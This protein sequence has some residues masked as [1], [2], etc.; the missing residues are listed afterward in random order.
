MASSAP[1]TNRRS[2]D[3]VSLRDLLLLIYRRRLLL[4][5]C[6]LLGGFAGVAVLAAVE[7]VYMARA[8]L[9]IEPDRRDHSGSTVASASDTLDSASVDSQVQILASR[10]LAREV[11]EALRLEGDP[12]LAPRPTRFD[13]VA[14]LLPASAAASHEAVPEPPG[15]PVDRFLSQLVVKRE[16]KSHVIAIAYRS[17]DP[18]RAAEI[19]NA[20]AERYMV[21]QRARKQAAAKRQSGWLDERL[22]ALK[23]Q[24]LAA[25]QGLVAFRRESDASRG[26]TFD[27]GADQLAGINVQLVT[28]AV[29]RSAKEAM[30]VRLKRLVASGETSDAVAQL[31]TSPL[32]ANLSALKAEALRREAELTAQYGARHPKIVDIKAEKAKLDARLQEERRAVVRQFESEVEQARAREDT[33]T[34]K[35]EELKGKALRREAAGERL[36]DL[37]REVELSRRLYETHLARVSEEERPQ[38][39]AEPDARVI[40]EAVPP[41]SPSFPDPRLILS[42]SLSSGFLLGLAAL[43][44][45]E[46]GSPGLCS[47]RE[48]ES[49]LG[50]PTL[51][52]TPRLDPRRSGGIAPHD[53]VVERPRSRSA[54]ALRALLAGLLR[55]RGEAGEATDRP[56]V[57]LVTSSLPREGKSTL[58][59]SLARIAAGEGLR[60]IVI[61]ADLRRPVLHELMGFKPC[62][63]LVEVLRR[64][65][66]L[67]EAVVKDPRAPLHLLPGSR[68]LAQPTRILGPHGLGTLLTALRG[69]FDL[70]LVDSAPLAAVADAKLLAQL[71]DTVLFAVRYGDTRKAFCRTCLDGLTESGAEVAG[72]VLTQVDLRRHGRRLAEEAGPA[73]TRIGEYYAD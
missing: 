10:S 68:R 37:Q 45:A 59:L 30:L 67:A 16:G 55:A 31:G 62:P 47:P 73:G 65:I 3:E 28:A 6:M 20:L 71:V 49:V 29:D 56:R 27:A 53:Y 18:A 51:A 63:G 64:E 52:L 60:V 9:L 15:D 34:A 66:T 11:I 13:L 35:L 42:L 21:G 22:A 4:L 50:L 33:L 57:V 54:E 48:V 23:S 25:E 72:V 5:L 8:Y 69:S 19:A 17:H 41:G 43:Y 39:T 26:E 2:D 7:P 44:L 1:A 12:V 61:D 36:R 32:L 40:S 24:L 58:T 70:V 14:R 38:V 46:A